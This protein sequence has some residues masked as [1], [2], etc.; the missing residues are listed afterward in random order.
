MLEISRR[1]GIIITDN[2]EEIRNY[3]LT[4]MFLKDVDSNICEVWHNRYSIMLNYN[5]MNNYKN[6][7]GGMRFII[8]GNK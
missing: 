3:L 5:K 1:G 7:I 2:L 8:T 4:N 6:S